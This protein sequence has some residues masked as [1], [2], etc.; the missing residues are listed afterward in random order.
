MRLPVAIAVAMGVALLTPDPHTR[1]LALTRAEAAVTLDLT[2]SD[3][4]E[5]SPFVVLATPLDH[6][7]L[8]EEDEIGGRR[9]VTYTRVR[10]ERALDGEG[11]TNQDVWVRTFGGKVGSIGQRVDGEAVLVPGQASVLFLRSRGD[12]T[13]AVSGMALGHYPVSKADDGK[14][15]LSPSTNAGL[16]FRKMGEQG[17]VARE[18]LAGKTVDEV[19]NLIANA[20]RNHAR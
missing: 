6:R 18:L 7:S 19:A 2:L 15:V 9:I 10:V 13:H 14:L 12:G 4:L 20:R 17:P 3:L 5:V 8:W 11:Q 16:T 1:S